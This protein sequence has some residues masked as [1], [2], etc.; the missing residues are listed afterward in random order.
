MRKLTLFLATILSVVCMTQV[1]AQEITVF[2]GENQNEIV[3]VY[4]YNGDVAGTKG[5]FIVPASLLQDMNG[6]SVTELKFYMG[7]KATK[8]WTATYEVFLEE[9]TPTTFSNASLRTAN[10]QVVYTGTLDATGDVMTITFSEPYEYNGGNLLVGIHK[11]ATG[12]YERAYFYGSEVT[13]G[14]WAQRTSSS[15]SNYNFAPK[16][17]LVYEAASEGPGFKVQ[18]Y[19]NGDAVDFGMVNPGTAHEFTLKNPGTEAVTV[20]ITTENGYILSTSSVTIEAKGETVVSVYTPE[21][22]ATGKVVFTPTAAGLEPIEIN[23]SC[24]IKD[25]NKV[26]VD[27]EGGALPEGWTATSGSSYYSWTYSEDK[28]AGYNGSSSS[29]VG[30]LT[31]PIMVFED[32]ETLFFNTARYGSSSWYSPSVSV[33][34]SADGTTWETVE[35]FTDDVYGTWTSRSVQIPSTTKYVRFRGWYFYITNIYGGQYSTAPI[36]TVTTSDMK[37]G[38]V[39]EAQTATFNIANTGKSE[40]TDITVASDNAEFV[41]VDAPATLAAGASADVTVQFTANT[42]GSQSGVVTVSAPEQTTVTFNVEGYAADTDLFFEDFSGNALP[43]GWTNT[44]WTFSDGAAIG[45]YRSSNKY[46]LVTPT[47]TVADGDVFAFEVRK[48]ISGSCTLPIYVSKDGGDYVLVKTI[49]NAEL[50]YDYD[51]IF[52]IEGL[53]AGNYKIKFVA[54]D[55]RINAVNGFRLN[56]NAPS[57]AVTP[58]T[59]ADFGTKVKTQPEAKVYTVTNVGTG[60]LNVE[61]SSD[62]EAFTVTPATLSLGKGESATFEIALVFDDN[63]GE[64][65]ATITVHPTNEGLSDVTISATATTA[66]PTIVEYDFEDGGMPT[67]FIDETGWSYVSN[68]YGNYVYNTNSSEASKL[69]LPKVT[70][71][72]GEVLTFELDYRTYSTRALAVKYSADRKNWTTALELSHASIPSSFTQYTVDNIP[73]GEWYIAFDGFNVEIDNIQGFHKVPV[74]NDVY[75]LTTN[76]PATGMVN[77]KYNVSVNVKNVGNALEAADYT[78]ELVAGGHVIATAESKDFAAGA[79]ETFNFSVTPADALAAQ[80][81]VRF[82]IGEEIFETE[83]VDVTISEEKEVG[84]TQVGRPDSGWYSGSQFGAPLATTTSENL[85]G[86]TA[87]VYKATEL[88]FNAGTKISKITYRGAGY[89]NVTYASVKAYIAETTD[90]EATSVDTEGM[91]L[92]YDGEITT[93]YG[94]TQAMPEDKFSITLD[95]PYLYGGKNLKL[96]FLVETDGERSVYTTFQ[97]GLGSTVAGNG[98]TAEEVSLATLA[99]SP[100]LYLDVEKAP[101]QISGVVTSTAGGVVAGAEVKVNSGDVKYSTVTDAEGRY[102]LNVLKNSLSYT[103]TVSAEGHD[104]YSEEDVT[105]AKNTTKNVVMTAANIEYVTVT[106]SAAGIASFSSVYA[107]NFTKVEGLKAY[108]VNDFTTSAKLSEVT[109]AVAPNTGLILKGAEGAYQVPVVSDGEVLTDNLLHATSN[110]TVVAPEDNTTI[111]ALGLSNGKAGLMLVAPGTT[112]APNKA[113]LI[114]EVGSAR[115]FVP[116]ESET[117]GISNVETQDRTDNGYNL[118]GQRVN[119]SYRGVVIINGKKYLKK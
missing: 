41:V 119:S 111:Y 79:K 22:T 35:T 47:L 1:R 44:G 58:N 30:T 21:A 65:A 113:Y 28:Y 104:T 114:D 29:Y 98:A 40:L 15:S 117:T 108:Q 63:Y 38:M 3:P 70:V 55:T 73:A 59:A 2:D 7:T 46:E 12:N 76:I 87:S 4:G 84:E 20:N 106:V 32:N 60:T 17:T 52:F 57:L 68:Y 83:A 34:V 112:I 43:E 56:E 102:T 118:N 51:K 105:F 82:T 54:D 116:F 86:A 19:K 50:S 95:E 85:F 10:A 36:M 103:F 53:E 109:V 92:I 61:L 49:A 78:V 33:Q 89:S 93:E 26:F 100:V 31:S 9:V 5:E 13:K 6:S 62:N 69:I 107:L 75:F 42:A 37:F 94:G 8:A 77:S 16:T 18:N 23:L 99:G 67:D 115:S 11:T 96:V 81:A 48:R 74:E 101:V 39:A 91:T 71:A 14:S 66:D 110:E 88:G 64:K 27:F 90:E 72:E 24:V 25:P 80:V 97:T 45:N